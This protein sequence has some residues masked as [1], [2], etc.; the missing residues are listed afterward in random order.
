MKAM[1]LAA[2]LGTRLRPLTEV[3]PKALAPVMG[4]TIFEFWVKRLQFMGFDGVA[5][6]AHHLA[7]CF[8]EAAAKQE[9]SI[10][11]RV[12]EE[13]LLLGTGG[14]IRNAL[15]FFQGEDF[16]VVNADTLCDADLRALMQRHLRS[17][18]AVS[19]VLHE[20]PRFNNV[21]VDLEDRILGFGD[22]AR[23]LA[24]RNPEIR[25]LA[26]TGIH[27]LSSKVLEYLERGVPADILSTYRKLMEEGRPP[28]AIVVS[29]SLWREMG[30]LT[31]YQSLHDECRRWPQG[32]LPP[33]ATGEDFR[34][35]S[36]ADL[37]RHVRLGGFVA[38]GRGC[39]VMPGAVLENTILWDDVVIGENSH[40]RHCI[41]A[42]GVTLT[43]SFERKVFTTRG[44][45][46][47]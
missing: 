4:T 30:T 26:F 33:L 23:S 44:T 28:R 2:G 12:Y 22:R 7:P 14:G 5:V 35:H 13:K 18:E 25:L 47:L 11:I 32:I 9:S 31:A 10:P 24:A 17:G 27:F 8:W 21:A 36:S 34:I 43:G 45:G 40:L 3:R 29:E 1:I 19:L 38:I 20:F 42:D 41:V 37:G 16:V 46:I 39:R 6:N 15:D